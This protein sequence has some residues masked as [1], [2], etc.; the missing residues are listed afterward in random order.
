MMKCGFLLILLLGSFRAFALTVPELIES[1]KVHHPQILS[2]Q[3]KREQAELA[4]LKAQGEFDLRF[5]QNTH[6]RTS[7]FY[8]GKHLSQSITKPL[9]FANAEL[10]GE[11]RFSDGNFPIYEDEYNTRT[12]GEASIGVKLSLLKNYDIDKR[13]TLLANA[14]AIHTQGLSEEQQKRQKLIYQGIDAYLNWYESHAQMKV[15]SNLVS[16]AQTRQNGIEKRVN[17][18]DLAPM[19]LHEFETTLISRQIALSQAQQSLNEAELMLG[20]YWR[21]S[22]AVSHKETIP[23]SPPTDIEW[24]FSQAFEQIYFTS[25]WVE[26]HPLIR[27]LNADIAIAKN[28]SRLAKNDYLPKLDMELKVARDAGS[29]SASLAGTE[30]YIGLNFSVPLERRKAKA[31]KAKAKAKIEELSY[32]KQALFEQLSLDIKTHIQQLNNLKGLN[33]LIHSQSRLAQK[34]ASQ[35]QIRF[36]EGDSDQFLLN[37]RELAASQAELA[38]IHSDLK[39]KRQELKLLLIT[40]QIEQRL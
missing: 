18:G 10:K 7:G 39:L 2:A 4:Q 29:G 23:Q 1:I 32:K 38:A 37:S 3:A 28:Q 31:E 24:P 22:K 36:N 40:G 30:S 14:N 21:T 17:S 13:R 6:F 25:H 35:E 26:Q 5:D 15:L 34:L 11:Y 33:Q 12:G 27:A 20:Y 19:S 8:H 16:L 9:H